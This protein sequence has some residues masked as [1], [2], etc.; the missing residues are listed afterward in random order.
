ME[1]PE[2]EFIGVDIEDHILKFIKVGNST[3]INYLV[4]HFDSVHYNAIKFHMHKLVKDGYFV[5][6]GRNTVK[7][8]D[9]YRSVR[10]YKR[11]K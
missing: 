6:M 10:V 8:H 11:I 5:D 3:Y 1:A 2:L 4:N 9:G 7:T